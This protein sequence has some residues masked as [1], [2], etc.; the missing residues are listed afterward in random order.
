MIWR[1][2]ILKNWSLK[3]MS[4]MV[5]ILLWTFVVGQEKAEIGVSI[6]IEIVNLPPDLVIANDIPT[7]VELRVYG[8]RSIIKGVISRNMTKVI[9]L[10]NA[11]PGVVTIHLTPEDFSLP[12]GVR[13][14][15]IKPSTIELDIQPLLRKTIRV[16]PVILGAV[17]DGY[18]VEKVEVTPA[19]TAISGPIKE[20]KDIE[21]IS[22]SP[23]NLKGARST[24]STEVGLNLQ[25]L[26]VTVEGHSRFKVTVFIRP[27]SGVRK[28]NHVPVKVD[29]EREVSIW[30]SEVSVTL[31]GQKPALRKLEI[32]DIHVTID[33]RELKPGTHLVEPEY[34]VPEEFQ[35]LKVT[36]SKIK[37]RIKRPRSQR[38][39]SGK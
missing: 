36:P 15:R 24:F 27:A 25:G 30:P 4:L 16:K 31:S 9:D 26:H 5:A 17:A 29:D 32:E 39:N 3:L 33:T 20:I 22:L 19:E 8:L 38:S 13:V 28:I 34:K 14:T 1:D 7:S 2:L 11:S 6:P 21:E 35:V 18:E 37:V 10:G 12:G 23:V